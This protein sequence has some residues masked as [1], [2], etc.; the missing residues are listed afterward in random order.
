[1]EKYNSIKDYLDSEEMTVD[2]LKDMILRTSLDFGCNV[3][4]IEDDKLQDV[5]NMFSTLW[6][7]N[8]LLDSVV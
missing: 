5:E 1:M 6:R 7:F 4:H 2:D 3:A 8:D